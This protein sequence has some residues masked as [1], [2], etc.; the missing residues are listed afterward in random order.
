MPDNGTSWQC[1]M[2]SLSSARAHLYNTLKAT[3]CS[4]DF[5]LLSNWIAPQSICLGLTRDL[6]YKCQAGFNIKRVQIKYSFEDLTPMLVTHPTSQSF[7]LSLQGHN[8]SNNTT[9]KT[10]VLSASIYFLLTSAIFAFQMCK[11]GPGLGSTPNCTFLHQV[12]SRLFC[13]QR[14]L[15]YYENYPLFQVALIFSI[16]EKNMWES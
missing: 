1:K 12:I 10:S 11:P 8:N 7:V 3:I 15:C 6:H 16:V 5:E 2:R 9:T 4:I 14:C 13:A